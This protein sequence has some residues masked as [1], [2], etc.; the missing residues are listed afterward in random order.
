[1]LLSRMEPDDALLAKYDLNFYRRQNRPYVLLL[2]PGGALVFEFKS[3][4]S[5]FDRFAAKLAGFRQATPLFVSAMKWRQAGDTAQSLLMRG[6]GFLEAGENELGV[7]TLEQALKEA[8]QHGSEETAQRVQISL[9]AAAIKSARDSRGRGAAL[10]SLRQIVG[11][12]V[13][14][15]IAAVAWT[16]IG[17]AQRAMQHGDDAARAYQEAYR[18]AP[19]PSEIADRAR[20]NLEMLGIALPETAT[21][22]V[23]AAVHL[24]YPHREIMVGMVEFAAT[25]P[26]SATRV[27]FYLDD[28][29][30]TEASAPFRAKLN[31]G[32][33]PRVHT[34]RA[35]AFD[36][37]DVRIG[38]D[39]KTVNDR[40]SALDVKIVSPVESHI[41]THARIDIEPRLPAG[42]EL[43]SIDLYWND[44]KLT[45]MRAAPFRYELDL[46]SKN[47]S[48]YIRA[49]VTDSAGN[50]AEDARLINIE[51]STDETRVDAVELHVIVQDRIGHAIEGLADHDFVVKE[52]GRPVQVEV[53]S[54][55]ADPITIG[56]ALDASGSMQEAMI[57]VMDDATEFLKGSLVPHDR[58]FLVAFDESA[59]L[60]QPLTDDL[61]H[62]SS[63]IYDVQAT[64]GTAVRD[65]IIYALDQLRGVHGKRALLVFT[66][67]I[68]NGSH[69]TP[70]GM[71][72]FAQQA[73]VPVYV[74]LVDT[75]STRT[76][77]T[78]GALPGIATSSAML[79]LRYAQDSL[80]ELAEATGGAFFRFP[81]KNDLPRLFAQV[82]D[83]TRGE[84]LL[85]YVSHSAKAR[86]EMRTISVAV[87]GH[88][89]NVR[90]MTGYY[91][92]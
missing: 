39:S 29:R 12:T 31:L 52:D 85:S 30:V 16:I 40:P 68:D 78:L 11:R 49:V 70:K 37:H 84:Y 2:D 69:T 81:R 75:E 63:A 65:S 88:A 45:T 62:V 73:G 4:F 58:T 43:T 71:I 57:H 18:L 67:G 36:T 61:Q 74:V 56:L 20:R 90:A 83:D 27:E 34:I 19:K 14:P 10:A 26:A 7:S 38:E 28:A 64:G 42:D 55:S 33:V 47:A 15:E 8:R 46:P 51:G 24:L 22:P 86:G 17:N 66:D 54:T 25:A 5:D 48:G 21:Q 13:N 92:R 79:Q 44:R 53:H 9:A 35:V 60:V 87:P 82:R 80:R 32:S 3:A 91:P 59:Y 41:E 23:P 89:A 76:P 6:S 1:M 77:V 72:E 50:T